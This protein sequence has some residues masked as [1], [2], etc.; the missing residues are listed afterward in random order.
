MI[1]E[2]LKVVKLEN[3]VS[4]NSERNMS[5]NS[6]K[7]IEESDEKFFYIF[8]LMLKNYIKY[9]YL[10]LIFYKGIWESWNEKTKKKNKR[11]N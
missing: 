11:F 7:I 1:L 10:W 2:E 9:L 5:K 3:Y 8:R 6:K 4:R